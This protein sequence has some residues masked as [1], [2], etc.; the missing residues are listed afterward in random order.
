[1]FRSNHHDWVKPMQPLR[2]WRDRQLLFQGSPELLSGADRPAITIPDSPLCPLYDRQGAD[3][4]ESHCM[5][6]PFFCLPNREPFAVLWQHRHA[7]D[8]VKVQADS[9]VRR[10]SL[11]LRWIGLPLLWR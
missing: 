9:Q 11:H 6:R 2:V 4:V 7:V 5:H 1:V 3:A 10:C 8:L